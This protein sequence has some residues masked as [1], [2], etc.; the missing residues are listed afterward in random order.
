MPIGP[1]RS[2][3]AEAQESRRARVGVA[4]GG[5]SARGYAHIGVLCALERRGVR[6]DVVVGTSFGAVVGALYACGRDLESIRGDAERLRRRDVFP[7]IVDVGFARGALLSGDRL[8]AYF[9]RLV[10]GR[11]FEDCD[12]PL[13]VVATDLDTGE[14][15]TLRS[16]PLAPALRASAS[17]PGLFAPALVD[18]R[19][20]IDGGIGTPVPL[21]AL[22]DER[23]DLA[24]GVGAGVEV[25]DSI[26]LRMARGAVRAAPG[27]LLGFALARARGAG[28]WGGLMQALALT[29]EAWSG[30]GER[31]PEGTGDE[32]HVQTR[33]P[34]S[35]LRFDRAA[36]AIIA[37][38]A[39]ME[40]AWPRLHGS[41]ERFAT[42]TPTPTL[43]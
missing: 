1:E 27:R 10:D 4:L 16:G 43:T 20:L 19:R 3:L 34:I 30:A 42:A 17:L 14:R 9:E 23:V 28:P 40:T 13:A 15:V 25:R 7:H 8:E 26:A 22:R 31:L 39:A 24:I 18:G 2:A 29:V 32:L 33:P 11:S 38:D 12:V 35:W 36:L 21:D 37:G 5:G 6:P 41:L